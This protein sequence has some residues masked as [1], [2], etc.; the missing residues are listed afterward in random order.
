MTTTSWHAK[1]W[2]NHFVYL[3][4][5]GDWYQW[6]LPHDMP[7]GDTII[8]FICLCQVTGIDGNYLMTCQKVIQSFCLSVCVRWL[9]SMTTTSWHFRRWYNHFVY[10][11]VS[12]DW[13]RWQLPHDMPEGDTII[14]FICLC[15]VTGIDDNYLMTFQK[16]IQSFCLSVCV[17]W[18]V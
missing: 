3:S 1:R 9:V 5:S 17:R 8:L 15:Q 13:Y 14:L 11:S 10:L 12:G 16:V 6:Q 18:L 2:Y 7:E 4:V